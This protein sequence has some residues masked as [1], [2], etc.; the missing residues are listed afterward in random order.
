MSHTAKFIE[1][2]FNPSGA[3]EQNAIGQPANDF[4]S[5]LLAGKNLLG[6]DGVFGKH[7]ADAPMKF[8]RKS[9]PGTGRRFSVHK[10]CC[11]SPS[12]KGMS[13]RGFD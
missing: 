4:R 12:V 6:E 7:K 8:H 1:N 5:K 10:S 2:R 13:W 9:K 11:F 3:N